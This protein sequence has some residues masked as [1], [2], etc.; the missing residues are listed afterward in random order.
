M[1]ITV[2]LLTALALSC[3]FTLANA[4]V[5]QVWDCKLQE[6]KTNANLEAAS[7][8]WLAAAKKLPG[9]DK[10]EAWH[11]F[12][13]AANAGDGDFSF[14]TITPDFKAWGEATEAYPGSS[15]DK[16][17]QAWAEVASCSGSSLWS[18]EQVK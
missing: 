5:V 8:V 1:N 11:N 9:N 15:T 6:G 14:V 7:S 3:T 10:L 4:D 13:V 2:R 16:A 12:P 17:D 18:S